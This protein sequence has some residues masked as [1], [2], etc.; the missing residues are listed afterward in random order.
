[1]TKVA[2][3]QNRTDTSSLEGYCSTIELQ[4]QMGRN[5]KGKELLSQER[6]SVKRQGNA[7]ERRSA[8]MDRIGSKFLL[9]DCVKPEGTGDRIPSGS[10]A[11]AGAL[12]LLSDLP[13]VPLRFTRG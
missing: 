10:F 7:N 3:G 6:V 5:G 8:Q 9:C 1:M 12:L 11:P 4:A 2:P 13:R